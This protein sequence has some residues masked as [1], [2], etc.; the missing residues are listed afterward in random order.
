MAKLK[1]E[2][3]PKKFKALP[4]GRTMF[5]IMASAI[6]KDFTPTLEEINS[7]NPFMFCRWLSNSPLGIDYA[8]YFNNAIDIPM[9][10]QYHFIRNT[11]DNV[12]Y[13][14]NI[15]K[16]TSNNAE[17]EILSEYYSCSYAVA[18]QYHKILPADE[19]EKI[20]IKYRHIG[21]TKI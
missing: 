10:A 11:V 2:G 3:L 19:L 1:K 8:N 9:F 12:K 21:R 20:L 16:D 15:K 18:K 13:I 6:K 4:E 17:I 5:S 7:I 14:V